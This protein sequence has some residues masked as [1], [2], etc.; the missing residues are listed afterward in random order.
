MTLALYSSQHL[1]S[2]LQHQLHS[3]G[4]RFRISQLSKRALTDWQVVAQ[5]LMTHPVSIMS[6]V[7]HAPHY[8][9]ATDASIQGM[10]GFWLPTI[11]THDTQPCAWRSPFP[12]NIQSTL[13]SN[14]NKLGKINNSDLELAAAITGHATQHHHTNS[15]AYTNTYLATDNSATQAWITK[16]SVSTDKPPA[17]LLRLLA[18]HCRLWNARLSSVFVN[19][20]TNTIADLLSR[21]FHLLD[22]QL[23]RHLQSLFPTKQPWRLV[24]P[25]TPLVSQVNCAILSKL[26]G[27]EYQL[28]ESPA[29]TQ[30]GHLGL[31]SVIP[32][33]KTFGSC[34]LKTHCPSYKSMLPDTEWERLLP[35]D[36]RSKL[37]QWRQPFV[38]WGRYS[39]HWATRT[40]G[41]RTPEKLTSGYIGSYRPIT[42]PTLPR[43]ESNQF[44]SK[45]SNKRSTYAIN[46]MSHTSTLLATC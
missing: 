34:P 31:S 36:L 17:F 21:S 11:M 12:N 18:Q 32:S 2:A 24:T 33:T 26:P 13:V 29:M 6:L 19:G 43:I 38:P 10:G 41:C 44:L 15:P 42:K 8:V 46:P 4:P 35:Q 37:A 5:Q 39:P 40:P 25:P 30:P 23:L 1:F 28:L 3:K 9:G 14:T 20:E 27:L 16:G 45:S 7:P 22:A